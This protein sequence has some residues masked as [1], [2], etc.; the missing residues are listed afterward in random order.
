VHVLREL[1]L[2]WPWLAVVQKGRFTASEGFDPSGVLSAAEQLAVSIIEQRDGVACRFELREAIEEKLQQTTMALS[3]ML[4][5]SP[6]FSRLE[7]GLYRLIGRRV[8]DA[9]V[10]S[11]R[12]RMRMKAGT[13]AAPLPDV[14]PNEFVA[15]VTEP[16]LKNE[17]YG[18]PTRFHGQLAGR[19]VPFQGPSGSPRGEARITQSGALSGFN[20]LFT[21]K[22]GDLF[23]VTVGDDGLQVVL[24]SAAPK[25]ASGSAAI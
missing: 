10:N 23:R 20:R 2:T 1:F 13:G 17:Q 18:V 5:S 11:A 14:K 22:A 9:A 16:A 25:D 8:G 4:G 24:V 7:H 3:V 21:P 15:R 6:I 19:C 12:T